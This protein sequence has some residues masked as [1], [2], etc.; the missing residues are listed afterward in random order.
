MRKIPSSLVTETVKNMCIYANCNLDSS[1]ISA[2]MDARNKN[3]SSA[4]KTALSDTIKNA[5]IAATKEV[6]TPGDV[7]SSI[8]SIKQ[9]LGNNPDGPDPD[10]P[11][12][13]DLIGAYANFKH[14]NDPSGKEF[15]K[16]IEEHP[17]MQKIIEKIN[18]DLVTM[19]GVQISAG[20]LGVEGHEKDEMIDA[21]D[22]Y[23]NP[24][25]FEPNTVD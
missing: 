3:Q 5:E 22:I 9:K 10:D 7:Q 16:Y 15:N 25:N 4:A 20:N 18:D 21:D 17:E 6:P 2:L 11:A 1:I 13:Q 24:I 8:N 14:G 19:D 12:I 23:I